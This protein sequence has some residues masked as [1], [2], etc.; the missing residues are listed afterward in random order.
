MRAIRAK[1]K[2]A[3]INYNFELFREDHDLLD[4]VQRYNLFY[5]K[6]MFVACYH[7]GIINIRDS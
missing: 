6:L 4:L 5:D 2:L 3:K 1:L 7:W